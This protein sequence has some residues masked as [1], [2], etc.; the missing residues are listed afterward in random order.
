M[1]SEHV[2]DAKQATGVRATS[3]TYNKHNVKLYVK[4]KHR[5]LLKT[6]VLL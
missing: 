6:Q 2:R 4:T 3:Q 5:L 1:A